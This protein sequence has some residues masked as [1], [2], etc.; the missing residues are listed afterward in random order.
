MSEENLE[1]CP[2]DMTCYLMISNRGDPRDAPFHLLLRWCLHVHKRGECLRSVLVRGNHVARWWIEPRLDVVLICC[3]TASHLDKPP[4]QSA[5]IVS[6]PAVSKSPECVGLIIFGM[7]RN[8]F[9][10]GGPETR[11]VNEGATSHQLWLPCLAFLR[12]SVPRVL[13]AVWHTSTASDNV[14][15]WNRISSQNESARGW[16]SCTVA[17]TYLP[18]RCNCCVHASFTW[19]PVTLMLPCLPEQ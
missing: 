15:K 1:G 10:T 18:I 16:S 7:D 2:E 19:Y 8:M 9:A 17:Q 11:V 6:S 12:S 5:P 14:H 3:S 13:V 4:V